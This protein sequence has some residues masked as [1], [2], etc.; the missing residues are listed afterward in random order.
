MTVTLVDHMGNDLSVVNAARVSFAKKS[1]T[2]SEADAGLIRFLA[3]E[4]HG[5][6]F[7]HVVM[8]F[9]VETP[10]FVARQW[11][12]HRIGSF[13]EVSG[14]YVEL[15]ERFYV[16]RV[17]DVRRQKG[18]PGNYTFEPASLHLSLHTQWEIELAAQQ[19]FDAYHSM[20]EKGI[21]KELARVVLP[22]GTYTQFYWTVN[23][24]ALTNFLSLRTG[25]EALVE[26]RREAEEVERLAQEVVPAC[27][28]AW[29]EGGRHPL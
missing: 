11:F 7:E 4:R 3:R 21:A 28:D 18:K 12:R 17:E 23:L 2:F 10:I 20:L 27:M 22:L 6:P 9:H 24:R 1:T 14:R 25:K 13:N 5:T 19:C 8:T 26:I 15:E 16:P 29:R